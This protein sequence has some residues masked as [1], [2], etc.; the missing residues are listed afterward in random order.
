M[1]E[2]TSPG[3]HRCLPLYCYIGVAASRDPERKKRA[4]G[5]NDTKL[6][7][8]TTILSPWSLVATL[9]PL[10]LP[11]VEAAWEATRDLVL[12]RWPLTSDLRRAWSLCWWRGTIHSSQ[13]SSLPSYRSCALQQCLFHLCWFS[14]RIKWSTCYPYYHVNLQLGHYIMLV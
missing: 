13:P 10:F 4:N 7:T 5:R 6:M 14:E 3:S 12:A 2:N 11:A 9:S 8:R 1:R